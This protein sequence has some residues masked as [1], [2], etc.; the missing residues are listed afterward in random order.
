MKTKRIYNF[1]IIGIAF[2]FTG[3]L[4]NDYPEP[5]Y[6]S[7]IGTVVNTD[8][9]NL[10]TLMGDDGIQYIV[11]GTDYPDFKPETDT[12]LIVVFNLLNQ[13]EEAH[14]V[15]IHLTGATVLKTKTLLPLTLAVADTVGNDRIANS[16]MYIADRFLTMDINFYATGNILHSFNMVHDSI[17]ALNSDTIKLQFRHNAHQDG[18]SQLYELKMCFDISELKDYSANTDSIPLVIT[19]LETDNGMTVEKKYN[20][21]YKF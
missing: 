1:I 18:Q 9:S 13:N 21:M 14:T 19:V 20:L 7:S 16:Q 17:L 10:F 4:P 11:K 12:R 3:C 6:I 5:S 8:E 2:A 15:D